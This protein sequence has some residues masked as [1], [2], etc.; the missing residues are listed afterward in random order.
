MALGAA[1]LAN[2]NPL[3]FYETAM[4]ERLTK[5]NRRLADLRRAVKDEAFELFYQPQFDLL[6]NRLLG[7]EALLRWPHPTEGM[8][9]PSEFIPL[10]EETGLIVPLG[11]WI[12]R[13]AVAQLH[14]WRE[15]DPACAS[16][17]MA[18]NVSAIQL[19]SSAFHAELRRLLAAELLPAGCLELEITE[20]QL[21][22]FY[23]QPHEVLRQLK[24]LG[25]LLAIDDLGTGYSS[26][27]YLKHFAVDKLKIDKSFVDNIVSDSGDSAIVEATI[28]M[29]H[30]LGM[31]VIAEGV[32]SAEQAHHL[33]RLSCDQL[34]GYHIS[35]PLPAQ[36]AFAFLRAGMGDQTGQDRKTFTM[37]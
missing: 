5:R 25:V 9:P 36:A 34:Q 23:E 32:E 10:L 13:T 19:G 29:A 1:Q 12:L 35:R 31:Q 11:N 26:L 16:V 8:I 28:A 21:M 15:A 2:A 24:D 4:N 30:K 37:S 33:R 7:F 3:R 14:A 22:S 20:S 17:I 6:H 27:S 18:V